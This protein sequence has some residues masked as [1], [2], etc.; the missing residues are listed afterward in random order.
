MLILNYNYIRFD[1]N[2]KIRRQLKSDAKFGI[3]F[4]LQVLPNCTQILNP[5]LNIYMISSIL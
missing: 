5:I 3:I 4:F 2:T 1:P